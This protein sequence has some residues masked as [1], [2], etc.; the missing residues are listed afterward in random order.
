MPYHRPGEIPV[1]Q[2]AVIGANVRALRLRRGWAMAKLGELMGWQ[3]PSTVC[4][5]EGYRSSWQRKFTTSEVERLAGIFGVS[6]EQ[7]N[8]RCSNCEGR[9]KV[10]FACLQSGTYAPLGT[11]PK[12]R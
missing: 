3:A 4:A 6:P 11:P 8:T 7:L 12:G 2:S 5:A 10:G 1:A 9:P